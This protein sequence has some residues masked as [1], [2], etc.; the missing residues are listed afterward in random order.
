MRPACKKKC[1]QEILRERNGADYG[2]IYKAGHH[3]DGGG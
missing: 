3:W 2:K 1:N